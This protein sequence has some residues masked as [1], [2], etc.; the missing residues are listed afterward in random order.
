MNLRALLPTVLLVAFAPAGAVDLTGNTPPDGLRAILE[1]PTLFGSGPCTPRSGGKYQLRSA[2]SNSAPPAGTLE[3]PPIAAGQEAC[4]EDVLVPRV[5][6]P[7]DAWTSPL[8]TREFKRGHPG[9]VVTDAT[10]GWYRILLGDGEAWLPAP[11][12]SGVHDYGGIVVLEPIH[13]LRGWDG[14]VCTT[15]R[16]NDCRMMAMP[17]N[18]ALRIT[19]TQMIGPDLWFKVEFGASA[20]EGPAQ[21]GHDVLEGWIPGYGPPGADGK[22]ALTLWMDPQ[23]C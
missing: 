7:G 8:P 12:S 3:A 1:A 16:P 14:R 20:C 10:G 18:P 23:G 2:P 5:R 19:R 21:P 6:K 17:A 22:R 15:P 9:L 4:S 11:P 13:T